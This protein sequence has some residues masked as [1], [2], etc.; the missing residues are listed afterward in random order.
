MAALQVVDA[1]GVLILGGAG[2]PSKEDRGYAMHNADEFNDDYHAEKARDDVTGKVF[3]V[4]LV[5]QARH[6][7][8]PVLY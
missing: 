5:R 1:M 2:N 7:E 6:E 8:H 3:N 4:E